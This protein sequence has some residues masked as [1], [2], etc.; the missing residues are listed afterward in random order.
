MSGSG[1][2]QI[3]D[4]DVQRKEEGEVSSALRSFIDWRLEPI[5]LVYILATPVTLRPL[6]VQSTLP[7][8]DFPTLS[9][10]ISSI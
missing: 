7:V 5:F 9:T 2:N 4:R 3:L 10:I 8:K 1:G 6:I